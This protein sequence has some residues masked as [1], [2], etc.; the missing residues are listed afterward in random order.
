M[1]NAVSPRSLNY[2]KKEY[3][4]FPYYYFED[5]L[6]RYDEEE[7]CKKFPLATNYLRQFDKQLSKRRSDKG[8][9]WFEYG[10]SQALMHL[11]QCKLLMSTLVTE[12]V[13]VS[14]LDKNTIPTSGIYIIKKQNSQDHV[15]SKAVN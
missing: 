6:Q 10:R 9:K 11:N 14:V 4:I 15:L 13:K 2:E 12:K 5:N 8:V 3:I 7:F 1:R